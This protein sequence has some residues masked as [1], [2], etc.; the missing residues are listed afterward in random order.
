MT[1]TEDSRTSAQRAL[2]AAEYAQRS[3][4]TVQEAAA[5][6]RV[7]RT[8]VFRIRTVLKSGVPELLAAVRAGEL[9]A[10]QAERLARQTPAQQRRA[11]EV[12]EPGPRPTGRAMYGDK[13][14]MTKQTHPRTSGLG[15]VPVILAD[16]QQHPDVIAT[17]DPDVLSAFLADL[18][19]A[20]QSASTLIH[21]IER[22]TR[23]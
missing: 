8:E 10:S 14:R 9:T 2:D 7:S 1:P 16:W 20:R 22:Q 5:K 13:V 23:P 12:P 6:Y 4:A 17:L 18:K 3:G 15:V 19:R 11:L 21:L